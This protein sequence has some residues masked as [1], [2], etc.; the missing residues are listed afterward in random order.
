[1]LA[2]KDERKRAEY[3]VQLLANRLAYLRAEEAAAAKKV[4]SEK[5][6][7]SVGFLGLHQSC[8]KEFD[9]NPRRDFQR[10][11]AFVRLR[12]SEC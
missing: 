4:R 6:F 3:D 5:D 2:V 9:R 11:I 8:R 10:L 12:A 7:T 1:M